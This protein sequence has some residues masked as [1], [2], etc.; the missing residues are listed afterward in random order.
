LAP[1][2]SGTPLANWTTAG[3][4]GL[5]GVALHLQMPGLADPAR[6]PGLLELIS[7]GAVRIVP[8]APLATI[9]H[10]AGTVS[11]FVALLLV[12]RALQGCTAPL[13]RSQSAARQLHCHAH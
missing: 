5:A 3:G 7:V 12:V 1:S 6:C 8:S 13:A 11:T 2:T 9:F 4:V 10:I